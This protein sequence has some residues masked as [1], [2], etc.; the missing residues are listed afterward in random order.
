MIVYTLFIVLVIH[1]FNSEVRDREKT[2]DS[3]CEIERERET[4]IETERDRKR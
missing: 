3:V 2:T 1:L 4:E